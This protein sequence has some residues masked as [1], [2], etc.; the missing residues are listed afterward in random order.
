MDENEVTIGVNTELTASDKASKPIQNVTKDIEKL[1]K[2]ADKTKAKIDAM[3]E[4]VVTSINKKTS[5]SKTS[6]QTEEIENKILE[7]TKKTEKA[8]SRIM[9][10]A[11]AIAG[12]SEEQLK[13]YQYLLQNKRKEINQSVRR[14]RNTEKNIALEEQAEKRRRE[15]QDR[16]NKKTEEEIKR[17]QARI[18]REEAQ[19]ANYKRKRSPK[20]Q[21]GRGFISAGSYL[22]KNIPEPLGLAVG[23]GFQFIG[24]GLSNPAFMAASGVMALTKGLTE[25][26]KAS[27]EAYSDIESIKTQLGVVYGNNTQAG[28]AFNE[29]SQYAIKSPFG[30]EQIVELATLLKQSGVESSNL[31]DTLKMLG[32]TAGGNMEKM[33]RIANNYAQ[34]VSIGKASMLDMRQFAYAGIPIFEK[35]AEELDVSQSAL[36]NMISDGKVTSEVIQKVFK[37]MTSEGGLFF[38]ATAKGAETLKARLTNLKDTK[39]LALASVGERLTRLGEMNGG[40]SIA[41]KAL[42]FSE[43]FYKNLNEK[44]S[45]KNLEKSVKTIENNVNS[46]TTLRELIEYAKNNGESKEVIKALEKELK[47]LEI[48]FNPDKQRSIYSTL[49]ESYK[50]NKEAGDEKQLLLQRK[51]LQNKLDE[52]YAR[53]ASE[54]YIELEQLKELYNLGRLTD[55]EYSLKQKELYSKNIEVKYYE[56]QKKIIDEQLDIIK[57]QKN[58]TDEMRT[59]WEEKQVI[60]YQQGESDLVS[61]NGKKSK[62]VI[63]N[64][65]AIRQLIESSDDYKKKEQESLL[66]TY[67]ET[68]SLLK[69]IAGVTKKIG[70]GKDEETLI[71]F[72]Q[73][74]GAKLQRY[75]SKGA[76]TARKLATT[77]YE[78][79]SDKDWLILREQ[80]GTR[81]DQILK[82][83]L[84]DNFVDKTEG[85]V[86]RLIDFMNTNSLKGYDTKEAFYKY[87]NTEFEKS[88]NGLD[89]LI[90]SDPKNKGYYNQVKEYLMQA[91]LGII[92]DETDLSDFTEDMINKSNTTFIPLWKRIISSATG[93]ASTAITD[94]TTAMEFYRNNLSTR[95]ATGSLITNM[96]KQGMSID[97]ATALT[98]NR[99]GLLTLKE[100]DKGVWQIDWKKTREEVSKFSN[101][102]SASTTAID[103]WVGSLEQELDTYANLI[104]QGLLT[105]E[106]NNTKQAMYMTAKQF[107]KTWT[108]EDDM[109][110]NAFG[111]DLYA[112][113]SDGTE[114]LVSEMRDG[115]AYDKEGNKIQAE[116]YRVSGEIL[117]VLKNNYELTKQE[118]ITAKNTQNKNQI[119]NN[120]MS[121]SIDGVLLNASMS[122]Q[123]GGLSS[124]YSTF[125]EMFKTIL[126]TNLDLNGYNSKEELYQSYLEGNSN[127]IETV[128][129]AINTANDI[130]NEIITSPTYKSLKK[131]FDSNSS[132]SA[133]NKAYLD[134]TGESFD[135]TNSAGSGIKGLWARQKQRFAEEG[136]A[137]AGFS[138]P[139]FTYSQLAS[140]YN[141]TAIE[142][143]KQEIEKD[144]QEIER[145]RK[146][147]GIA[148]VERATKALN[149]R[150]THISNMFNY[151]Y[152]KNETDSQ[153]ILNMQQKAQ[154]IAFYDKKL[155]EINKAIK[156]FEIDKN[157]DE[158]VQEIQKD[159]KAALIE[160]EKEYEKQLRAAK[161]DS[162]KET[163]SYKIQS[164]LDYLSFQKDEL[165]NNI[166][167]NPSSAK[168]NILQNE[169]DLKESQLEQD[170]KLMKK[171]LKLAE[172]EAKRAVASERITKA[173]DLLADS[174]ADLVKTVGE[175]SFLAPFES[176]GKILVESTSSV[177]TISDYGEDLSKTYKEIATNMLASMGSYMAQAGFSIA[178]AAATSQQWGL[179]ATGLALAAAGGFASGMAGAVQ[180]DDTVTNERED[181]L[182]RLESLRSSLLEIIQ[183]AR[184]DAEY[185]ERNLRHKNA[186]STAENL[187][188]NDAI[189]TPNG[190]VISTHPEDY[191]IATKTPE[192]LLN[193][194]PS[195]TPVNL[196]INSSIINNS[197]AQV[198][199]E[200]KENADGSIDIVTIIEDKIGEYIASD[201]SDDAFMARQMRIAGHSYVS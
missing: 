3:A 73:V 154:K 107:E 172:L 9:S 130:I 92:P 127:A 139:H 22:G 33:K 16:L 12:M 74:S 103:T 55:N 85:N 131:Y 90:E 76:V 95:N 51:E 28:D 173:T 89:K 178:A 59:W 93:I 156:E 45:L 68:I 80:L 6:K 185:Y 7:E 67:K 142:N 199:Q 61:E 36:R 197:S 112:V 132:Q 82:A 180:N 119:L 149:K 26:G 163:V 79:T 143:H 97:D 99:T 145:L 192:T 195:G 106:Q 4:S 87:F 167:N 65:S 166:E 181:E 200:K 140:N 15:N 52:A 54:L 64:A 171:E 10:N 189:I 37:D 109:G 5:K 75:I 168:I 138:D 115:I 151:D 20:Y 2:E 113:L 30:V 111:E 190:N 78:S 47:R 133:A 57:A 50:G 100:D 11:E 40:D 84:D 116:G 58:I 42:E 27:I 29:L 153:Y 96:V 160:K 1:G 182:K 164:G 48:Q 35:V 117:K 126:E 186:L 198:R 8:N 91:L 141:Q 120:L 13:T 134:M 135:P 196:V 144:K 41:Y 60:N 194:K 191:L 94:A 24:A 49:Y 193:N 162:L 124:F 66:Q 21:F 175:K 118:L 123:T 169:L 177:K 14:I 105:A 201:K 108:A 86:S 88:I 62:S 63:N 157:A 34:I 159:I 110:V 137:E 176:L 183:Q 38:E 102:L 72:S 44:T 69:E 161:E 152:K 129:K 148:V 53:V 56:T 170:E 165:V 32:D 125:P 19:T 122:G 187:S 136:F 146:E 188:V 104:G 77:Q 18:A 150:D 158:G 23:T 71:D 98:S 114:V 83:R 101:K 184:T 25:L 174:M 147:I 17:I 39:Q 179:V 70:E 121:S 43:N 81:V 46:Q 155:N 31:M 128:T